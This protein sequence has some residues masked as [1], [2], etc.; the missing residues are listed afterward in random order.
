MPRLKGPTKADHGLRVL[1]IGGDGAIGRALAAVLTA[2]GDV[3]Y[4][5]TRRPECAALERRPLL[6]LA[7]SPGFAIPD[8]N[9]AVLCAAVTGFAACRNRP[10]Q[11]RRI[12]VDNS[13]T[14]ARRLLAR[15]MRIVYLSSSAAFDGSR[16][17]CKADDPTTPLTEYGRQKAEA[18]RALRALG[19]EVT[20][21]RLTKVIFPGLSPLAKWCDMLSRNEEVGAFADL[22]LAP[23]S[24]GK[25]M[26][27]LVAIIDSGEGSIFQVAPRGDISYL[28]AAQHLARRCHV[29]VDLV[30]RE[31]AADHNVPKEERP[32]FASMDTG[33]LTELTGRPAPDPFAEIDT[34]FWPRGSATD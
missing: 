33:R 12:N 13:L 6:D 16:A 27:A 24:I 11:S 25:V 1:V 4:A 9:V 30:R 31:L 2:R 18:E 26:D 3:V 14:L 20:I 7:A 19:S 34:V 10:E 23:I 22:R 8:A 29:P 32:S 28:E 21:V 17:N 15:G 5:T